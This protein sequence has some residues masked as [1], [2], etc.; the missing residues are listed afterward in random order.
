SIVYNVPFHGPPE[1]LL[2]LSQDLYENRALLDDSRNCVDEILGTIDG[3]VTKPSVSEF[4]K[5]YVIFQIY[6]LMALEPQTVARIL[7]AEDQP[8]SDDEVVDA[9][10]RRISFTPDDVTIIDWNSAIVVD[11]EPEDT[12]AVLEFAN[13]ELMEMRHL[14]H[15]CDSALTLAYE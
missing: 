12:L 10:S 8:L 5:D 15:R 6:G 4:V 7:R 2:Q 9:M 1:D 13:V 11:S 3:A 14:D